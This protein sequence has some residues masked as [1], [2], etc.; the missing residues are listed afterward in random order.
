L[1]NAQGEKD[2]VALVPGSDPWSNRCED[3]STCPPFGAKAVE[4]KAR[5]DFSLDFKSIKKYCFF[6][7]S[8]RLARLLRII[9]EIR[10]HPQKSPERIAKDQAISI[11]QFYYDR[12]QLAEMGFEFS[13]RK[14]RFYIL[15]DPVVTIGDLPL[16]EVLALV[17][18]TRHL[19]AAKDFSVVWRALNGLLT[20]VDHMPD[21]QKRALKSLVEDVIIRD[22]FGCSPE[23]LE[24]ILRAI[25]EKRRILVYSKQRPQA[26][27]LSL[28][29]YELCFRKSN[30]HV[31]AYAVERKKR[32]R[33]GMADIDKVVFTIFDRPESIS[34]EPA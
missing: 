9:V 8:H 23:I 16:S 12:N 32:I 3:R 7:Q 17:L 14:G 18:A 6:M 28:D 15:G 22:G 11:R 5:H 34:E 27:P 20:M 1:P 25:A 10:T 33:Y 21:P 31:D 13:R 19:F 24:D 2:S 4:N 29:P 26:P 30:L